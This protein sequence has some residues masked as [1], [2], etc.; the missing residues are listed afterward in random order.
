MIETIISQNRIQNKGGLI[1]ICSA[2][3]DVIHAS[4]DFLSQNPEVKISI[5]ST[6]QQVN[7]DG[8]YTGMTPQ[9][10][11]DKVRDIAKIYNI[12]SDQYVLA[13]DHLG[14]NAWKSLSSSKAM[15]K[16]LVLVEEYVKAGYT[17]LH[18]DPSMSCNDD[19]SPLSIEVIADRTAILIQRAEKTAIDHLGSSD[20]LFYIVGTE[21][22]VPG[23][24]QE[25]EDHVSVTPLQE[26]EYTIKVIKEYLG[27]Y[28]LQHIWS[29]VK[30]VVVQ[31]GVEFGD[32]FVFPYIQG[33]AKELKLAITDYNHLVYEA[34]STDYQTTQALSGLV[35]DHFAILKV[36]PE[37]TFS[38]REALFALDKIEQ[39]NP[40]IT[41]K[42]NIREFI[43]TE[44]LAHPEY[45]KYYYNGSTEELAFKRVYSL[46]DRIRYYWNSPKIAKKIQDSYPNLEKALNYALVSQY[47]PWV[48]EYNEKYNCS[49]F[50]VQ[51]ILR[52]SVEK[53]IQKY[54]NAINN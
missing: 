6:V 53:V 36:G 40:N 1:C 9:D 7:Q 16:S 10:F 4:F 22:P 49:E 38:W 18:I 3:E 50:S 19:N 35:H 44:M 13:G 20:H 24:S 31:P 51:K 45:W 39:E 42:S 41:P 48:L 5:E 17:K 2:H 8:G 33:Q 34:H 26:V 37:L 30:G 32:D 52:W 43:E 28:N 14:P 47:L 11:S 15:G 27:K 29:K 25:H 46:S 12:S 21:V 54:F 23:G